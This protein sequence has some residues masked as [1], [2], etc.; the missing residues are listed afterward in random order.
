MSIG[1]ER[2]RNVLGGDKKQNPEKMVKII[3]SEVFF[4]LKDYFEINRDDVDVGIFMEN[5]KYRVNINFSSNAIK[6]ANTF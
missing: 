4:L 3:K 1:E 2:L 5:N 6:I